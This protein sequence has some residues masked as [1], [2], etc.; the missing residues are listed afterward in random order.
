MMKSIR[1]Y[2]YYYQGGN[3]YI[4]AEDIISGNISGKIVYYQGGNI[5]LSG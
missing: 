2:T 3:I 1:V 4:S 5:L